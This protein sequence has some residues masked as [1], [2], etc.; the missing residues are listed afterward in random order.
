MR[1]GVFGLL[2]LALILGAVGNGIANPKGVSAAGGALS[3]ILKVNLQA[4]SGQKI[5]G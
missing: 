3:S 4:A 2:S 5:T 1:G